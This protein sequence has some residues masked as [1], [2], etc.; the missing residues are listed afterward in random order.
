MLLIK[1]TQTKRARLLGQLVVFHLK[2]QDFGSQK[3]SRIIAYLLGKHH[4]LTFK[5]LPKLL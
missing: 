2:S 1:P 3:S 5:K 4:D